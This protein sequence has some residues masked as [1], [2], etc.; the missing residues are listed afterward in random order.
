MWQLKKID[1]DLPLFWGNSTIKYVVWCPDWLHS[2]DGRRFYNRLQKCGCWLKNV[3]LL[4]DNYLM[5]PSTFPELH[6]GNGKT[7]LN[8]APSFLTKCDRI[9]LETSWLLRF[10]IWRISV[11]ISCIFSRYLD[12]VWHR[13]N[14]SL[15]FFNFLTW[16]E[17]WYPSSNISL[18]EEVNFWHH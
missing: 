9:S 3:N 7:S 12:Q 14:Q 8:S 10:E 5:P 18:V 16:Y 17:V 15:S 11:N 6:T 13:N 4:L 1:I 2:T